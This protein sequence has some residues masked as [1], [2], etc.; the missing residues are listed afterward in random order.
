MIIDISSDSSMDTSS[1]L[2]EYIKS[3]VEKEYSRFVDDITRVE[4]HLS[5]ENGPKGSDSFGDKRCMIE[6]RLRGMQPL[7]VTNHAE[8]IHKA[9]IGACEKSTRAIDSALGKKREHRP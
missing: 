2:H 6:V 1:D 8:N 5:D 3:T 7:A 9:I 4:V